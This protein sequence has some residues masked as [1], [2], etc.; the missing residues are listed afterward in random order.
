[1]VTV[2]LVLLVLAAACQLG[3]AVRALYLLRITGSGIPEA[4][5]KEIFQPF[6]TTKANGTGLG[7]VIVKKMMAKME[8][9]IGIESWTGAGTTVIL[10]LPA[11]GASAR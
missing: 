11:D 7:L 5:R 4:V 3:A 10:T 1:M 6:W 9:T 2:H 8:G